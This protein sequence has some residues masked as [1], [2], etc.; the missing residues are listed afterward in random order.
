MDKNMKILEWIIKEIKPNLIKTI[1]FKYTSYKIK[2]IA[3]GELG[4]YVDNEDIIKA[5]ELVCI[6]SIDSKCTPLN[7]CYPISKKWFNF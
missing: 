7:K 4:F 6:D 5:M 1:N 2:H 3:E